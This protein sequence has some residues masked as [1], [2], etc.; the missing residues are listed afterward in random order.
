[1]RITTTFSAFFIDVLAS[2]NPPPPFFPSPPW[3]QAFA[4]LSDA[5]RAFAVGAGAD[6]MPDT[7][8]E[9]LIVQQSTSIFSA[10]GC[11]LPLATSLSARLR[12]QQPFVPI[13]PGWGLIQSAGP[14]GTIGN[15]DDQLILAYY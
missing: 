8:D 15:G 6:T 11:T 12:G 3:N 2:F 4:P 14:N 1:M 10:G 13:G 5:T 9:N 7:G